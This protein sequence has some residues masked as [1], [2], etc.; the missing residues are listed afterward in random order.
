MRRNRGVESVLKRLILI[1]ISIINIIS[2]ASCGVNNPG[3]DKVSPVIRLLGESSIELQAQKNVRLPGVSVF[4]NFDKDIIAS[5]EI[6]SPSGKEIAVHS[7]GSFSPVELGEYRISYYAN[8]SSGNEAKPLTATCKIVDTTKPVLK[9]PLVFDFI[10]SKLDEQPVY[11]KGSRIIVP[12]IDS[13]DFFETK[14]I[15][16]VKEPG[17]KTLSNV[18]SINDSFLLD[19]AGIYEMSYTATEERTNGLTS[20]P[21]ILKIESKDNRVINSFEDQ[22]QIDAVEVGGANL[23]DGNPVKFLNEKK[24][25]PEFVTD[26]QSS[27][28]IVIKGTKGGSNLTSYP[29]ITFSGKSVGYNN[30]D[31]ISFV[32]FDVINWNKAA[33]EIVFVVKNKNGDAYEQNIKLNPYEKKSVKVAVTDI[34]AVIKNVS[35]ISSLTVWTWGFSEGQKTFYFDNFQLLK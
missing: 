19:R 12:A 6:K 22:K 28:K 3:V 17:G 1:L 32:S 21:F 14:I 13:E 18:K 4:D 15:V 16:Q 9:M 26:G 11:W 20:V 10:D 33:N 8:D 7:D 23:N 27:L 29:G 24:K 2:L 30:Y 31:N 35:Y 34:K 5:T 25:A